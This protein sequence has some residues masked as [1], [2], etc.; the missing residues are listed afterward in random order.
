MEWNVIGPRRATYCN[1][2]DNAIR[3]PISTRYPVEL[4][5]LPPSLANKLVGVRNRRYGR[6]VLAVY[7]CRPTGKLALDARPEEFTVI[8]W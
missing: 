7:A 4:G 2:I 5:A 3:C 8:S 6:T 1:A